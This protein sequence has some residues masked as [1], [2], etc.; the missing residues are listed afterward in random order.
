M[1]ASVFIGLLV[2]VALIVIGGCARLAALRGR[3]QAAAALL[4]GHLQRRG[5]LISTMVETAQNP[6]QPWAERLESVA[7]AGQQAAEASGI[8][9]RAEAENRLTRSLYLF[10]TAVEANADFW[11]SPAW[12]NLKEELR[13]N[14]NEIFAAAQCYNDRVMAVNVTISRF[15]WYLVSRP[16]GLRPIEYFVLDEPPRPGALA[17][18]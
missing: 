6:G 14:E 17:K 7:R 11:A 9:H 5:K 1:A 16:V 15:P 3:V 12:Q 13:R 18:G 10:L 2:L 8:P 4:K